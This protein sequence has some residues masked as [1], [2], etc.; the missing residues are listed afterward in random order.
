MRNLLLL[1]AIAT[2]FSVI[3]SA[4]Q[5]SSTAIG[6]ATCI[7]SDS[8]GSGTSGTTQTLTMPSATGAG[9]QF[10]L[11]AFICANSA[12][13][14]SASG[15]SL[16][17]SSTCSD[18]FTAAPG[19]PY[20]VPINGIADH[21][22]IA[23]W[24][25]TSTCGATVFTVTC[26]STCW[27]PTV[28]G[29]EW[30]G[31]ATSSPFDVAAGGGGSAG[32]SASLGCGTTTNATDLIFAY[33]ALGAGNAVSPGSGF[34]EVN[35][36]ITGDEHEAKTVSATGA[37]TATWSWTGSTYWSGACAAVKLASGGGST[38]V[39]NPWVIN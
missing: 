28:G 30:T 27:Y 7:Q 26:G 22:R 8:E 24:M 3:A 4:T 16:T 1:L 23:V 18:T 11:T 12:C 31:L 33:I 5:C 25:V 9:H 35:E 14:S 17:P 38:F 36:A 19:S 13:S 21:A 6:T 32:T 2:S 10:L 37:Q 15:I 39:A 20:S 29:S 34:T